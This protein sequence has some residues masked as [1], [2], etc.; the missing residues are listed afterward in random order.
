[1]SQDDQKQAKAGTGKKGTAKP[2]TGKTKADESKKGES[3]Q[4]LSATPPASAA[5]R[6][7]S[8]RSARTTASAAAPVKAPSTTRPHV[9]RARRMQLSLTRLEPWSVAKV[10]FLLSIAGAIIQVVAAAL[11]WILLNAMGLFDNLTQV[12]SKTG[13]DAG[14]FDLG[15]VLSL[16]TVLSSVT[17]FSIFEIVIV[18]AL[19]TI[20][21]FLYN[22]VSSLVGGIHVTLGDD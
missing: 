16:G 15:Q 18:V 9:P 22:L 12:I 17:I 20:F 6:T 13:L 3:R 8:G 21:A 7:A 19:V 4:P 14:G 11:L 5:G 1:M 10:T 2:K